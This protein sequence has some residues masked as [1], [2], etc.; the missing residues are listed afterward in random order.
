MV[1][2]II[3]SLKKVLSPYNYF[4]YYKSRLGYGIIL[5]RRDKQSKKVF[6]AQKRDIQMISGANNFKS[7]RQIFKDN[8]ILTVISLYTI[9]EVL[10]Y[11][12]IIIII[13]VFLHKSIIVAI[14]QGY[15]SH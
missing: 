11:I 8:R 14:N 9:L 1:S 10:F 5:F 2:Y 15:R 3:K 13:Y 6:G 7:C 4:S 12:I